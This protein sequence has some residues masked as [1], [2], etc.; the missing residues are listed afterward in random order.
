M[1]RLRAL[2][3]LATLVAASTT[4]AAEEYAVEMRS[5]T[6]N[7]NF[8]FLPALLRIEPG[9]SVRFLAVVP[10]HN[11]ETI[12]G[13]VPLGAE[14]FRGRINEEIVVTFD[15]EGVYGY[16]CLPHYA[17]GQIGLIVVGNPGA[18][19]EE[20]ASVTHPGRARTEFEALFTEL[21]QANLGGS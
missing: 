2:A 16:K 20:A 9:D 5:T 11:A 4:A 14:P 8:R 10:G 6:D 12:Q 21:G 1:R 15:V 13:M 3:L 7:G 18:N 17:L 19:L